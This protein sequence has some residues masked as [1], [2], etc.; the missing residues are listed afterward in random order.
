MVKAEHGCRRRKEE[1]QVP[2]ED[3]VIRR[4]KEES[5]DN[6]FKVKRL[7]GFNAEALRNGVEIFLWELLAADVCVCLN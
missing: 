4:K 1:T 2:A 6:E 7:D 5:E 3:N